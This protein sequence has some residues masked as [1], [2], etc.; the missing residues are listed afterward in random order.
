[1]KGDDRELDMFMI[2]LKSVIAA[3][4]PEDKNRIAQLDKLEI[5]K[6][7]KDSQYMRKGYDMLSVIDRVE[8]ADR[9]VGMVTV[10]WEILKR[11]S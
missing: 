10:E 6:A 4:L 3:L 2:G 7:R 8:R 1:M 5:E 11:K 9:I